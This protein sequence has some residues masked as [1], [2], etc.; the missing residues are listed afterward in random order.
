MAITIA[1]TIAI[2]CTV[3]CRYASWFTATYSPPPA[4]CYR[5]T[6]FRFPI[7]RQMWFSRWYA[8]MLGYPSSNTVVAGAAAEVQE[9]WVCGR[10]CKCPWKGSIMHITHSRRIACASWRSRLLV[11]LRPPLRHREFRSP[12]PWGAVWEG[13]GALQEVNR[14]AP[15]GSLRRSSRRGPPDCQTPWRRW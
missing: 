12:A 3:T 15:A 6:A 9:R 7:N 2:T 10:A 13:P 1:I 14:R 11:L 4:T 8:A 5:R